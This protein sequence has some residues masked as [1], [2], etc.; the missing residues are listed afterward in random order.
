MKKTS[1]R[2]EVRACG[3]VW[4]PDGDGVATAVHG[5]FTV[6]TWRFGDIHQSKVFVDYPKSRDPVG[7]EVGICLRPGKTRK[8]AMQHGLAWVDTYIK[9]GGPEGPDTLFPKL[10]R[11]WRTIY[12]TRL[13]I[14]DHIFFTIGN[15]YTWLDGGIIATSD[16]KPIRVKHPKG[17]PEFAT[18]EFFALEDHQLQHI[19]MQA[20]MDAREEKMVVGPLPDDGK[21][22]HF[23]PICEYSDV[24]NTPEDVR[25]DWLK[26]VYEAAVVLR[27][28]QSIEPDGFH[29]S[30][31][32]ASNREHGRKVVEE[33]EAKYPHLRCP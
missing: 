30:E 14:I 24:L 33:L 11:D 15:G 10:Y 23:Y 26:V 18:P 21:P 3:H 1:R 22:R 20:A 16:E 6:T 9:A 13:D 2:G 8:E 7:T 17:A 32:C 25:E 31:R 19:I 12:R 28:R 4:K 27:D 29:D 5:R